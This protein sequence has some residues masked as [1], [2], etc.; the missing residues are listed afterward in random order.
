MSVRVH[1]GLPICWECGMA[2]FH[3]WRLP[4]EAVHPETAKCSN[5]S[6]RIGVPCFTC[7]E[8]PPRPPH[9]VSPRA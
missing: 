9:A 7:K 5:S 8:L 2:Y 6:K 1:L 3:D 4:N